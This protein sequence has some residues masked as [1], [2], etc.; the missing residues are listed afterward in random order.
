MGAFL[1][2]KGFMH[3]AFFGGDEQGA[4]IY[5][6]K[7]PAASADRASSWSAPASI[8]PNAITPSMAAL[9]GDDKGNLVIV[10]SGNQEGNGLY[11]VSSIDMGET[12]SDPTPIFLTYD[13]ELVP[14]GLKMYMG[15]SGILHAAWCVVNQA[16]HGVSAYYAKLEMDQKKWSDPIELMSATGFGI[17]TPNVIEYKGDVI[18][19]YYNFDM[20]NATWWHRSTDG[21]QT[22]SEPLRTAPRHIG[23]N[24]ATSLII[25]SNN[26]LHM[27]FGQRIDDLSHGMWHSVWKGGGWS[28]AE[29]IVSGPLVQG[30]YVG[31][32]EAFD[33]TGAQAVISQ[34]NTLLVT[35]YTDPGQGKN[36]VWYSYIK[37]DAPELPLIPLPNLLVSPTATPIQAISSPLT[38]TP[39]PTK[40]ISTKYQSDS[41]AVIAGNPMT[42]L[43]MGIIPVVV[44]ISVIIV[45]YQLYQHNRH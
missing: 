21:G 4:N 27:L 3:I 28:E 2:Q 14:F 22:W 36:G 26:V 9:A 24:G 42:P 33:P 38:P 12:W 39:L 44:L 34:G 13:N 23:S 31:D 16:G 5:Y 20:N 17:G 6:S 25:D 45:T 10:Y 18:V 8:G 40:S 41:S 35:W 43:I 32:N 11:V 1:D 7:A 19:T 37:L 29:S 15:Q 30:R